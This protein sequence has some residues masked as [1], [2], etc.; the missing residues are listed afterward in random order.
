MITLI[1]VPGALD[2]PNGMTDHSFNPSFV[3]NIVF[4]LEFWSWESGIWVS[5][6]VRLL[7]GFDRGGLVGMG[8]FGF[9]GFR[10]RVDVMD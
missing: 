6:D 4:H 2:N 10:F 3:L 9:W 5:M 7:D 8:I 1:K